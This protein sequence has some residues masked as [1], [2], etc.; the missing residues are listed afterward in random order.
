MA[1]LS[2]FPSA[3]NSIRYGIPV[4]V[5]YRTHQGLS[6]LYNYLIHRDAHPNPTHPS[7][8]G[9]HCGID[10][11]LGG[12]LDSWEKYIH[13]DQKD[14]LVRQIDL[15]TASQ[16]PKVTAFQLLNGLK[17]KGIL[18]A[19]CEEKGHRAAILMFKQVL[20]AMEVNTQNYLNTLAWARS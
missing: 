17:S 14:R 7:R 5:W 4:P 13:A 19:H 18:D 11:V 3:M 2:V 6:V 1:L 16:T 20:E 12:V 9:V 10:C 8:N 15:L